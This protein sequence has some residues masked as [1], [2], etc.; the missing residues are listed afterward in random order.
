MRCSAMKKGGP[1][2]AL[3]MVHVLRNKIRSGVYIYDDAPFDLAFQDVLAQLGQI[4][5]GGG[6]Y[7][8][9]E[10]FHG[11]NN[12]DPFPRVHAVFGGLRGG[13]RD[14]AGLGF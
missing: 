5:Q 7:H 14:G 2:A 10:L 13:A 8:R 4:G 9:V 12:G 6:L 11:Q 1:K 3:L